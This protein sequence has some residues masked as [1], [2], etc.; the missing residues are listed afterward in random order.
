MK[1][2]IC[3]LVLSLF[4]SMKSFALVEAEVDNQY[5]AIG[6][7]FILTLQFNENIS[8]MPDLKDLGDD[9]DVV[10]TSLS[11]QSYVVNGKAS[12]STK[13]NIGLVP[14]KEGE[15]II[16]KIRVGNDYS[17]PLKV[18]VQ[19]ATQVK[20]VQRTS[21]NA[22]VPNQKYALTA[23]VLE[24]QDH[25]YVQQQIT[26]A[27]FLRDDGTIE[28]GDITFEGASDFI[29]KSLSEPQIKQ[30]VN[31]QRE[32]TYLYALFPQKS[33]KI[34]LPTPHFD[35]FSYDK[36]DFENI[37]EGGFFQIK[38]PSIFGF[39]TPVHLNAKKESIDILPVDNDYKGDWWLPSYNVSLVSEILGT[40]R[41]FVEG[42]PIVREVTLSAMGLTQEQL[43]DIILNENPDFKQYIEEQKVETSVVQDQILS[44]KKFEITYI[45]QKSGRLVLP[46]IEIDF[47]DLNTKTV[48][49][50]ISNQIE[51]DVAE[52]PNSFVQNQKT[53]EKNDRENKSDFV[54]Y[55]GILFAFLLGIFIS[56]LFSKRNNA[57]GGKTNK[58]HTFKEISK[59]AKEGD[60]KA[61]RDEVI[62]YASQKHK[63]KDIKNLKD[64]A[65]LSDDEDFKKQINLLSKELYANQGSGD[66]DK[67]YFV[68]V[69]QKALESNKKN[70]KEK[71]PLP[72]L[73][74]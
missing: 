34:E 10:S 69:C 43:P 40:Q 58:D 33:G 25:P 70:D 3:L 16:P 31:G 23:K 65:D 61:L 26:Y 28:S 71:E 67:K 73:Y 74:K 32:I 29:I 41:R 35:G 36:P 57:I 12:H 39:Q 22:V 62:L 7:K 18:F 52:N 68:K 21:Q 54:F 50:A 63:D 27:V 53:F 1:R 59:I 46:E 55:L 17:E 2:Y 9:F 24:P 11:H 30:L 5:P 19:E 8:D 44:T 49:R 15:M 45:P 20:N 47:F 66:L 51:I 42:T 37:F 64:V 14:T 13:W 56:I 4:W 38:I 60:L 6:E 72:P 48:K